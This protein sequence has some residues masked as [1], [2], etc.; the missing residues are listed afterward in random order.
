MFF[1]S[2]KRAASKV[3]RRLRLGENDRKENFSDPYGPMEAGPTHQHVQDGHSR[4]SAV[5]AAQLPQYMEIV[6]EAESNPDAAKG[7]Q[8]PQQS[9]K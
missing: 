3:S 1:F 2:F 9:S 8:S 5:R 7:M 6:W 4:P